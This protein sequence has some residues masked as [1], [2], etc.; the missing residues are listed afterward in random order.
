MRREGGAGLVE[1]TAGEPFQGRPGRGTGFQQHPYPGPRALLP[2]GQAHMG[3]VDALGRLRAPG[4]GV[5]R[6]AREH[7]GAADE[8]L[9][10]PV[11]QVD[12]HITDVADPAGTGPGAVGADEGNQP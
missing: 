10:L 11:D 3:P 9:G 6:R 8:A 2:G 7:S 4:D 5:G 1:R 12:V